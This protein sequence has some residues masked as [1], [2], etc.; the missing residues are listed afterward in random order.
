[1]FSN[2][3]PNTNVTSQAFPLYPNYQACHS[4]PS[5]L[6]PGKFLPR[7]SHHAIYTRI[8]KLRFVARTQSGLRKSVLCVISWRVIRFAHTVFNIFDIVPVPSGLSPGNLPCICPQPLTF[9]E[10]ATVLD[11]LKPS[12]VISR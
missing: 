8:S 11:N 3:P 9:L 6:F 2:K 7:K 4:K 12:T 5:F 1:M 10:R